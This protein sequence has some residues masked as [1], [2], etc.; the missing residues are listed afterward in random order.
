MANRTR[1]SE[2]SRGRRARRELTVAAAGLLPLA[3]LVWLACR[4]SAPQQVAAAE[5]QPA[6]PIPIVLSGPKEAA[7]SV[8]LCL[9]AIHESHAKHDKAAVTRYLN[10]LDMA[11]ARDVILRRCQAANP[12]GIKE[13]DKVLR[14]YIEGWVAVVGYYAD[15]LQPDQVKAVGAVTGATQ[16]DVYANAASVHGDVTIRL[17]CL[18]GEDGLWRVARVDFAPRTA[19]A[20]APSP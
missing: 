8:L 9:R 12:I 10:Q 16:V 18:R 13:P 6:A 2:V 3:A 15:G 4:P 11:A 20:T 17:E 7:R 19:P 5:S 1:A 14:N